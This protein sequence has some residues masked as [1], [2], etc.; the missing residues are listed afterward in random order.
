MVEKWVGKFAV[1]TGASAGIGAAIFKDFARSGINVIGLARRLERIEAL[2]EELGPTPGKAFA[3]KCDV[4]DPEAVKETFKHIQEKFGVVHILVNNA[5]IV[6]NMNLLDEG[7]GAFE[8]LN[9]IMDTNVRG[10][11]QC[12]REAFRLMK[13]S[14]DYG[15]IINIT[16]IHSH[17]VPFLSVSQNLYTASKHTV[18]ALT[19]TIRQ[20]L[21]MAGNKKIRI[22][23]S[24][25]LLHSEFF[26][27]FIFAVLGAGF[28][29]HRN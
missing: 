4:S 1:V 20:E 26:N 25:L 21:V 14:G 8:M 15:L 16:S 17:H 28:R 27:N 12:T 2:I 10:L 3:R 7:D 24:F 13:M 11:V 23:A 9:E 19:E 22:T 5:G 29:R 18:T 6:K